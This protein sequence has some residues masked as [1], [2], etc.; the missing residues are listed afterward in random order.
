MSEYRFAKHMVLFMSAGWINIS[1]SPHNNCVDVHLDEFIFLL[2][3]K[4]TL[5]I[6]LPNSSFRFCFY[7]KKVDSIYEIRIL[8]II[9]FIGYENF[10]F[11]VGSSLNLWRLNGPQELFDTVFVISYSENSNNISEANLSSN[12]MCLFGSLRWNYHIASPFV[13]SPRFSRAT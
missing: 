6:L 7:H 1:A 5:S 10:H 8:V 11:V 13:S 9:I 12:C 4:R 2:L 3:N